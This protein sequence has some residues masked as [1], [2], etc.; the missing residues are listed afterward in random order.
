VNFFAEDRRV[1]HVAR[2]VVTGLCGLLFSTAL[3]SF[4]W[5]KQ[6][7]AWLDRFD[8]GVRQRQHMIESL[9]RDAILALDRVGR[10]IEA[11]D[12][13][14][15]DEFDYY[16]E[17]L[18]DRFTGVYLIQPVPL[19][20]PVA[21]VEPGRI[22]DIRP[23]C[24]PVDGAWRY[25][26]A[27]MST[28]D[29]V[30]GALGLD[31]RCDAERVGV[32]QRARDSGQV[33]ATRRIHRLQHPGQVIALF[34]PIYQRGIGGDVAARRTGLRG[35]VTGGIA[36]DVV[37]APTLAAFKDSRNYALELS[38]VDTS[39]Q[40]RLLDMNRADA[41]PQA[42]TEVM[43]LDVAGRTLSLR[44]TPTR[45]FWQ[46][47][48]DEAPV[49]VWLAG[50]CFTM[51]LVAWLRSQD[52][53]RMQAEMLA[54]ARNDD[55][56]DREARLAALFQHSPIAI[57]RC[58]DQGR[59]MDANPATGRLLGCDASALPGTQYVSLFSSW[60][61]QTF[62]QR[63]QEPVWLELELLSPDGEP[64]PVLVR[65]LT[66]RQPDGSPYAWVMLEDLRLVRHSERLK[67]EFV[68][69]VSHELRTPLTAIK[70][71]LELVQSG[72]MGAYPAEVGQLLDMAAQNADALSRL[73]NDL[74]DV[75]RLAQG[76]LSLSASVQPL[77]PLVE[78]ARSLAQPLLREKALTLAVN[79][80]DP[81]LHVRVDGDRLVQVF[82]N[83][84][85]NAIK[86]S[87]VDGR[88]SVDISRRQDH[89]R[90]SVSDEGEG[91]PADFMP[92]LFQP[93]T[94]ADGSDQRAA[95]GSGL[96]LAISQG[97][98]ERM[99]GRIHAE[100][101]PGQG[102]TFIIELPCAVPEHDGAQA[103]EY[104]K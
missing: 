35:F 99:G 82:K 81:G 84:L 51:L 31:L 58:D 48:H 93:F 56:I 60:A 12:Q 78:Q 20:A 88:I 95:G 39:G 70:G 34:R 30:P 85:S 69:T 26:L 2:L 11:S 19:A 21:Q 50:M 32:M 77:L 63:W 54:I 90:I 33:M 80:E 13:V 71:A 45:A 8:S 15:P 29:A 86:F 91:I 94:Q 74:L 3:A 18:L 102:A 14:T 4:V 101:E 24:T 53:G 46:Q 89:V 92:R 98:I 43:T 66:M 96:G 47:R 76:K 17:P 65:T 62:R 44:I 97:L 10:F 42:Q 73:I 25:P 23:G 64:I 67:R 36:M 5:E 72:V 83:L 37:L 103:Q 61:V 79:T 55:V 7:G 87:P 49:L 40:I 9:L 68:A 52:Q 57:L 16:N 27:L 6:A 104:A 28:R 59:I 38:D 22:H 75:E 100:S 1:S 41:E